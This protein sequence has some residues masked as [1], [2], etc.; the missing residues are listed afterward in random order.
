MAGYAWPQRLQ[1]RFLAP[2]GS[3][4]Q[5]RCL[6]QVAKAWGASRDTNRQQL[7][8]W[9]PPQSCCFSGSKFLVLVAHG[10]PPQLRTAAAHER[11]GPLGSYYNRRASRGHVVRPYTVPACWVGPRPSSRKSDKMAVLKSPI[12]IGLFNI[13]RKIMR[14]RTPSRVPR[15]L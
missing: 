6:F 10:K 7:R 4:T 14:V 12:M 9:S 1:F 3:P 5:S 13:T 8:P 2:P 15:V 11:L